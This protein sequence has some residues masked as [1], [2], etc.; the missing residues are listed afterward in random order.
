VV[1]SACPRRPLHARLRHLKRRARD[2]KPQPRLRNIK[3]LG[4]LPS[5]EDPRVA[6][7][8]GSEEFNPL[9]SAGVGRSPRGP[10]ETKQAL[11]APMPHNF[12]DQRL[13]G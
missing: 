7:A 12:T 8:P 3:W 1:T 11:Q 2:A 9:K 4:P 13:E 5:K 10:F 6:R